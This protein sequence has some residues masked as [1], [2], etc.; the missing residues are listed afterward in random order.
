MGGGSPISPLIIIM[1]TYMYTYARGD[2]GESISFPPHFFR[3]SSEGKKENLSG[4]S[5][6][7]PPFALLS[8]NY[9]L[10]EA[11]KSK[12]FPEKK[13]FVRFEGRRAG[14][15]RLRLRGEGP[16]FPSSYIVWSRWQDGIRNQCCATIGRPRPKNDWMHR[17]QNSFFV[18]AI[19]WEQ[20]R[21]TMVLFVHTFYG[22]FDS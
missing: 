11:A 5:S 18:L 20:K 13:K 4:F 14:R 17:R 22:I 21:K 19:S 1:Y 3:Y 6:F 10:W 16:T 9:S 12:Q 15:D 8:I 2:G 7:S